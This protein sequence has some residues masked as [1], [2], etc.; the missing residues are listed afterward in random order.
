MIDG[1]KTVKEIIDG[2]SVASFEAI[3]TVY[4]LCITG[5]VVEQKN[6]IKAEEQISDGGETGQSIYTDEDLLENRV[7]D[8]FSNL[9]RRGA[10]EILFIDET[11]DTKT[12]QKNYYKLVRDFHPDQHIS[13]A[14]PLMLDKLIAISEAIQDAYTLLK[15]DDKRSDYFRSLKTPS[16]EEIRHRQSEEHFRSELSRVNE[17]ILSSRDVPN[18]GEVAED[19]SAQSEYSMPID[20]PSAS[21]ETL[22]G[23]QDKVF[24]LE[25]DGMFSSQERDN[26]F[27]IERGNSE[28]T[29]PDMK[30]DEPPADLNHESEAR[31]GEDNAKREEELLS[32]QEA[33][34]D[35]DIKTHP[36]DGYTGEQKNE[37]VPVTTEVEAKQDREA[38]DTELK[39]TAPEDVTQESE[40]E[41]AAETE[42]K[43]ERRRH[44]RFKLESC[45][46]SGEMF[47][48][49]EVV[50]LDISMSGIA[51]HVNKQ[52]KVGKEYLINLQNGE[53]TISVKATV[54]RSFLAESR[55]TEKGEIMPI[56]M[57]GMEFIQM[58]D[59]KAREIAEFIESHRINDHKEDNADETDEKRRN[60]RYKIETNGKT[61]LDFHEL[62]TI[63]VI[64]LSGMLIESSQQLNTEDRI[65]MQIVLPPNNAIPFLGRIVSCT[66]IDD[67]Q[68]RYDIGIEYIEMSDE[69]RAV[70]K[71][72]FHG[73]EVFQG[74]GV[75]ADKADL[76]S[77]IKS[78]PNQ[79]NASE[80]YAHVSR[81]ELDNEREDQASHSRDEVNQLLV[82]LIGE[83]KVLLTQLRTELPSAVGSSPST[84]EDKAEREEPEKAISFSSYAPEEIKD[85]ISEHI[86][87][88]SHEDITGLPEEVKGYLDEQPRKM[89]QV[90]FK[91]DPQ[92]ALPA[93]K[94]VKL[95]HMVIPVLFLL[96]AAASFLI[97]Y[98]PMK[99]N[100][101]SQPV[102]AKKEML[103]A[104]NPA[105][106]KEMSQPAPQKAPETKP[107]ETP[108][109]KKASAAAVSQV[110]QHTVELIAS[111]STW[112][113][114]TIDDKASKEMILKAGDKVKWTAKNNV[115]LIIGNAAGLK[116]IFDGK[117]IG[118]L[119][120][121]GKVV[122]LKLPLSKNS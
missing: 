85:D 61:I 69:H 89:A 117:E 95:W 39:P 50:V 60:E 86:F 82:H 120:E 48:A 49:S 13:S 100:A 79:T 45:E 43:E 3:K 71:G 99:E 34:V 35:E 11:A 111:E 92:K 107:N 51:L 103:P 29:I 83:I 5:F 109:V 88:V 25:A 33:P 9:Y 1:T 87:G 121:K 32:G 42:K 2:S 27:V 116:V 68:E 76:L 84:G 14:D 104:V 105:Q 4:V 41:A 73:I 19:K 62:Y 119:G 66:R 53:R 24:A 28:E 115:S 16:Q 21:E 52:L 78:D 57:V 101:V 114:A 17:E 47:F 81:G 10:H 6:I 67:K 38:N 8:L 75:P 93:K 90:E 12:V 80:E 46:V 108:E 44:Q 30:S 36:A 70:L 23:E 74:T 56:Y 64:S 22:F 110:A 72:F 106:P 96:A 97:I 55:T 20:G 122:R 54:V 118:T 31:F 37:D 15:D 98:T 18:D 112:L 26:K 65:Q 40:A 77:M 63:K 102:R 7:N 59:E 94:R 91:T 113:S 58:S